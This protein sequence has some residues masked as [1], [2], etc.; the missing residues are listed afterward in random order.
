MQLSQ[1]TRL[2]VLGL[3]G[4]ISC[5]RQPVLSGPQPRETG[6]ATKPRR[7]GVSYPGFDKRDFPG[8]REMDVWYA[9]SPYEWVGYYLPAPC[10][11]G[12]SW[13]G[14]RQ[15]LIDRQ[16]GLA[17]IYVGL[18]ARRAA[19]VNADTTTVA[20]TASAAA[21]GA[22]AEATRCSQ[23]T[24]SAEQGRLDADDAVSVATGDGF[25]ESTTIF[26]DVERADPYPA[27]LDTYVRA[28]VAQVLARRFT[29]GIY[30]HRINAETLFASAR[31]AYTAA[32][33]GRSPPFWVANSQ[34]FDFGKSPAESGFAFATIWQNP[35][36]ARETYANVTFRV[37]RNV[38]SRKSPSAP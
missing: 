26:L 20:D 5:A 4:V 8:L 18:Q 35:T 11:A 16:W 6:P 13:A 27:E 17:V 38:A 30:G 12:T 2:V 10:Y 1:S 21:A 24:L 15:E 19:A 28:W 23:N 34:G 9:S 14:H 33:D 37:D 3:L 31:G 22:G 25:P 36:N 32:G 29:P 7:E